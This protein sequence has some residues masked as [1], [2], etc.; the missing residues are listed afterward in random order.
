MK[1]IQLGL[2]DLKTK[3]QTQEYDP[4]IIE[5]IQDIDLKKTAHELN[6][7]KHKHRRRISALTPAQQQAVQEYFI[8]KKSNNP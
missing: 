6:T 3:S 8:K 1:K 4:D 5:F 7:W 2:F